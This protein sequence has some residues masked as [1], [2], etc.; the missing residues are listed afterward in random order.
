MEKKEDLSKLK[1]EISGCRRCLLYQTAKQA[2]S[3]EGNPEAK[4]FLIGEAPGFWEDR[5]GKPFVGEAGKILD[6]LLAS[7]G[8]GREEIFI[9]NVVKHRPPQNRDP[10]KKEIEACRFWLWQQIKIIRP[11]LIMTLGRFALAEFFPDDK[12]S[13]VHG[14]KKSYRLTDERKTIIP[15]FH[16]AAVLYNRR[17]QIL[18][19]Q[20][21]LKIR[22]LINNLKRRNYGKLP[23]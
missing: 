18:L 3:G 15:M 19:E 22:P 17:M 2:V 10:G 13:Q 23:I 21:F 16:P 4:I 6:K 20:D 1:E 7:I 5:M 14:Q 9:G 8:L 12:I 11:K